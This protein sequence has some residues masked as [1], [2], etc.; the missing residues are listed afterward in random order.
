MRPAD[1]LEEMFEETGELEQV[2]AMSAKKIIAADLCHLMKTQGVSKASLAKQMHTARPVVDRLLDP[3]NTGV[4]LK[5]IA[6][7]ASV[8]GG[9]IRLQV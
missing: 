4:T 2:R 9:T 3:Q 6:K 7:A 1:E 5:T 8:L